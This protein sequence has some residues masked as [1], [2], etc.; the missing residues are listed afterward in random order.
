MI[1]EDVVLEFPGSDRASTGAPEPFDGLR[2]GSEPELDLSF[3]ARSTHEGDDSI[4]K[5]STV[6]RTLLEWPRRIGVGLDR[7][8]RSLWQLPVL[9]GAALALAYVWVPFPILN[10]VC[11]IPMLLWIEVNAY[12]PRGERLQAGFLFGMTAG[13]ISLHWMYSMLAFSWL[14]ALLYV[15]LVSAFAAFAMVGATLAGWLRQ[16]TGWSFSLLLPLSWIPLEWSRTWGD[17][18]MT[19]DHVGNSLAAYPFLI[20]F[21]DLVGP[22]GVG[23]FMLATNG[24]AYEASRGWRTGSGRRAAAILIALW[25]AILAYDSWA[26]ARP[27]EQ[28]R[29]LRVAFVQPNIPLVMKWD[30]AAEEEQWK[31]LEGMTREAAKAGADVVFWPETARPSTF[32]HVLE[33]P[34]TYVMADVQQL[35]RDT[36]TGIV[37]GSEYDV[38]SGGKEKKYYNAA[39]SV[40]ATGRLDPIWT[41]KTYLVPFVEGVPFKSLLGPLLAGKQGEMRWLGGGFTPGPTA[42]PLPI[43]DTKVGLLVCYEE[44]YWDLARSLR[45]AGAGLEAIIT[46]DAWFGRTFFQRYQADSARMR[47][48]ENRCAFVRVANTGI[49]GFVDPWG[50]YHARTGLFEKRVGVED[51]LVTSSLTVYDRIGDLMAWLAIAGLVVAVL[52]ARRSE[53]WR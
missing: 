51:I 33:R 3:A 40:H 44:L 29:P 37:V 15:V 19:A 46:N 47:A 35:A 24:L 6:R 4:A 27:L 5:F 13:L 49:S 43:V 21:A 53:R 52:T 10:F 7:W 8:T 9:S 22:Y 2:R 11:F 41:A 31:I 38:L 26:W 48:I 18:R 45:N 32:Y 25:G 34:D 42:T 28:R 50:R 39:F 17:L 20:Q 36:G 30:P 14:A 16:R 23:A 1:E 12:R